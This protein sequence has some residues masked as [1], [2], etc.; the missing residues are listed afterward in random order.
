MTQQPPVSIGPPRTWKYWVR[1]V[2]GLGGSVAILSA[3][4]LLAAALSAEIRVPVKL[5]IMTIVATPDVVVLQGTWIIDR[6]GGDNEQAYPLQSSEIRCDRQTRMCTSATAEI[7]YGRLLHVE[8]ERHPIVEWAPT[9]VVF[10]NDDAICTQYF[11]S[12]DVATK[13]A[14]GVRRKRDNAGPQCTHVSEE[15]RLRLVDGFTVWQ[16]LLT[17]ATPW[18]GRVPLLSAVVLTL[19]GWQVLHRRRRKLQA[20]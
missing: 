16:V 1:L 9:R 6:R 11:Y 10:V 20:T 5:P 8:L 14:T 4:V 12:V 3:L 13:S 15:L 19:V 18:W 2:L 17:E 7:G